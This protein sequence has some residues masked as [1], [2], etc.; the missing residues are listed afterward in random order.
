VRD[1][2]L[3]VRFGQVVATVVAIRN[4]RANA[5]VPAGAWLETHVAVPPDAHDT[6][7]SVA[8]AVARLARARPLTLHRGSGNLAR[9]EGALEVV[10]PAGDIEA[11]V[12][13]QDAASA[14][15]AETADRDRGRLQKELAEA[16][17][18]L[19]AARARLANEAFTSRAPEAV[20]AGARARAAELEDQVTRLRVRLTG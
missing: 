17:G 20:V 19:A 6:F 9:P 16:E 11:T 10:L 15:G 8:G 5:D 2:S 1:A 3:D 13:L 14:A 4:A 18:H 7:E 12:I